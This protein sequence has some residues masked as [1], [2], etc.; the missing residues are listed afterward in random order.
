M[1][2]NFQLNSDLES[3]SNI[4]QID[5]SFPEPLT[6]KY[7]PK[8]CADFVGLDKAKKICAYLIRQPKPLNRHTMARRIA[9]ALN[10]YKVGP[11]G[12]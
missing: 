9:N 7:R 8:H 10:N 3:S 2:A 1:A 12:Y 4:G 5:F 11:K 6:E